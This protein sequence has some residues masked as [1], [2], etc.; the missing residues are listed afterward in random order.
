MNCWH[1]WYKLIYYE[2]NGVNFT[3]YLSQEKVPLAEKVTEDGC[4]RIL[5]EKF[6]TH[7][8]MMIDNQG[9]HECVSMHAQI[10][11]IEQLFNSPG[12]F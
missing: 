3:V 8:G 4:D 6:L 11:T 12:E 2:I 10:C 5:R 9:V 1:F 7:L